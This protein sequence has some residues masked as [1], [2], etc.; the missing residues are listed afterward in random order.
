MVV[1]T[2]AALVIHVVSVRLLQA[3]GIALL[4]ATH[5]IGAMLLLTVQ[6]VLNSQSGNKLMRAIAM[7]YIGTNTINMK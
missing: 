6:V 5:T 1:I 4:M 2:P 3:S 7:A